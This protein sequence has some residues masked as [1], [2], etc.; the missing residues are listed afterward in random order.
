MESFL[1]TSAWVG[2]VHNLQVWT[3][4]AWI[5]L[6]KISIIP[7]G[8]AG[9]CK[10]YFFIRARVLLVEEQNSRWK[11]KEPTTNL[12]RIWKSLRSARSGKVAGFSIWPSILLILCLTS[13]KHVNFSTSEKNLWKWACLCSGIPVTG[14][15]QCLGW[16]C[17]CQEDA[18]RGTVDYCH[19]VTAASN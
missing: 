3:W 15:W 12:R 17:I 8:A 18:E 5:V 16:C 13:V 14:M 9:W 10:C 11:S 1:L 2:L 19:G 6:F 4:K 7:L